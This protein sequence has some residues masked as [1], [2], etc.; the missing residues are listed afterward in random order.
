MI[1]LL[2]PACTLSAGNLPWLE[3]MAVARKNKPRATSSCA[4]C[5]FYEVRYTRMDIRESGLLRV[6][7]GNR[8]RYGRG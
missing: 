3:E 2:V 7:M 8:G 6:S 1:L 5:A 4:G